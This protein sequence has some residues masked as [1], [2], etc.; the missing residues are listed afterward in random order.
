MFRLAA[1]WAT[2]CWC[3]SLLAGEAEGVLRVTRQLTRHRVT[4]VA[5]AYH[6]GIAVS[7]KAPPNRDPIFHNVFSLSKTKTF[8]LGN[9]RQN[10]TRSVAF[11][12][13]G[14]VQVYCHLHPNMAASIVVTPNRWAAKPSQAAPQTLD[15]EIPVVVDQR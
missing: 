4:P 9:C 2:W 6:R 5:P 3:A 12:K 8:D 7:A 15:F 13:P 11:P 14:I 10:E 1:L